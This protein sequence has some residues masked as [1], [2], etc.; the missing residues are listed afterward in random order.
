MVAAE[1]ES[2][3]SYFENLDDGIQTSYDPCHSP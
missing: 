2:Q 1:F 3:E